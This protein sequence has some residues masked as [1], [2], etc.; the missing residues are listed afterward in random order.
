MS[1]RSRASM[2]TFWMARRRATY[3]L[4]PEPFFPAVWWTTTFL[5]RPFSSTVLFGGTAPHVA[6]EKIFT[7][8]EWKC[9]FRA[10]FPLKA[11]FYTRPSCPTF[12]LHDVLTNAAGF[13]RLGKV[14][15]SGL[16]KYTFLVLCL[17]SANWHCQV[18]IGV[19]SQQ[20]GRIY[21]NQR[22]C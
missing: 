11:E 22:E 9:L 5:G 21:R 19:Y 12:R 15:R 14:S 17:S 16:G 20:V 8:K 7:A 6:L 3:S 10:A 4:G 2:W 18:I 13:V 1:S